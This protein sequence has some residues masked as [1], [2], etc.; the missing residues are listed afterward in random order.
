MIDHFFLTVSN[1]DR[2]IDFY[3]RALAPLGISQRV[4]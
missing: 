2:S 3:T 1:F 4:D